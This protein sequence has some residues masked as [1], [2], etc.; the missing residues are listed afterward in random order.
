METAELSGQ[1]RRRLELLEESLW[2]AETR[3][4]RE[5][6]ESVLAPGFFEFGR[7]GRVYS[8]EETLEIAAQPIGARLP[9]DDFDARLLSRDVAQATYTSVAAYAGQ[10]Q[11]ANRSSLWLRTGDGWR[12]LFHQA[13]AVPG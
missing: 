6:M 8:R 12:L 10:E 2:R 4:D 9:L 11:I 13:T 1:D 3:F 7:S 5:W